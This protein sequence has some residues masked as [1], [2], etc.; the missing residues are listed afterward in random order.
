MLKGKPYSITD[1]LGVNVCIKCSESQA[2]LSHDNGVPESTIHGWL[3][4]E[5][6][7][8]DFVHMVDSTDWIKVKEDQYCATT[9]HGHFGIQWSTSW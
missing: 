3:G 2:R 8:C 4:D 6:K 1:K 9:W 7:L 5:E